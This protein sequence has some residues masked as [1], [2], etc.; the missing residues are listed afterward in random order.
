[1]VDRTLFSLV[2]RFTV[3]ASIFVTGVVT[4]ALASVVD[5]AIAAVVMAVVGPAVHTVVGKLMMR[6]DEPWTTIGDHLI[7]VGVA[8]PLVVWIGGVI[9]IATTG[10]LALALLIAIGPV[11]VLLVIAVAVAVVSDPNRKALKATNQERR[12]VAETRG[13]QFVED[14]TDVLADR[15]TRP[16]E[17]RPRVTVVAVLSGEVHGWPV[18][19]CDTIDHVVVDRDRNRTVVCMVHL[20]V[21]LPSTVALPSTSSRSLDAA[22]ARLWYGFD[23]EG[24]S[25]SAENVFVATPDATFG[26]RLATPEVRNATIE[27]GLVFWRVTGRDLSVARR[28]S[29]TAPSPTQAALHL[30]SRLVELAQALPADVLAAY[31][32]PPSQELPFREPS[33]DRPPAHDT[34]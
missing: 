2:A 31:G 23:G 17:N 34:L 22:R 18:T 20:P 13:W 29:T 25:L 1:V 26:A 24:E 16:G 3:L 15:W 9:Y 8:Y 10:S 6:L 12:A 21:E 30:T 7:L 4:V 32:R 28:P 14:G 27:G 19:I 33:P 5:L 11:V